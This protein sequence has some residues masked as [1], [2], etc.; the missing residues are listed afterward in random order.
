MSILTRAA[1]RLIETALEAL[2]P[3]DCFLCGRALPWRQRGS[4][5]L[6][7]WDGIP[8]A[9]GLRPRHGRLGG[10]VWAAD[11]D[12]SVRRLILGM[13]FERMDYLGRH[14]GEQAAAR[15]APLLPAEGGP[16]LPRPDVV[17]PVP[18][19]WWRLYRRG[20]NQAL[21]IARPIARRLELPLATDLLARVGAGRR[22]VGLSR[23]ERALSLAGCYRARAVFRRRGP[24]GRASGLE[25]T[26]GRIV[27]LV[28]DVVTTGATLEACARAL[29]GAGAR[30]VVAC[31]VAR[32]PRGARGRGGP[33]R[34]S[35]RRKRFLSSWAR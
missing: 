31:V 2:F 7:C 21:L 16:G 29:L 32:T 15:L 4:V 22:Q 33:Q 12:G 19:H 9:P 1:G 5:C 30:A 20:Y 25:A 28:D 3:A 24:D 6:P 23:R 18:M 17:V 35:F 14:L 34:L 27:L 10:I 8:W 11:F 26:A 13:K